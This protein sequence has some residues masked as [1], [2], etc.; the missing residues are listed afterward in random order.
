MNKT[1]SRGPIARFISSGWPGFI[2]LIAL[3]TAIVF[4]TPLAFAKKGGNGGGGG[5]GSSCGNGK[6]ATVSGTVT[7]NYGASVAGASVTFATLTASCSTTTNGSGAYS[8]K[9]PVA[10]YDVTFAAAHHATYM[11]TGSVVKNKNNAPLNAVLTADAPVIVTASVPN[12]APDAV[13]QAQG[14]YSS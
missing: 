4:A 10:S 6:S 5:G 1:V 2:C 13:L 3:S 9:V 12:G 7:N 11:V 14:D 8:I